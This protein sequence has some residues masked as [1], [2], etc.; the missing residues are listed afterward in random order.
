VHSSKYDTPSFGVLYVI[1]LSDARH[2]ALPYDSCENDATLFGA[3]DFEHTQSMQSSGYDAPSSGAMY[4][5]ALSGA[6]CADLQYHCLR[7]IENE[8]KVGF[9]IVQWRK[10][11]SRFISSCIFNRFFVMSL[12]LS[13]PH[14]AQQFA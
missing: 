2:A 7:M 5:I 11:S 4:V 8:G 1:M 3:R 9:S 13:S 14:R 10:T 12:S 6:R